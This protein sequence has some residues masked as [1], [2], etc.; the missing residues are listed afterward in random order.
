MK[1]QHHNHLI[2]ITIIMA[3]VSHRQLQLVGLMLQ[4]QPKEDDV[5]ALLVYQR[6]R[7]EATETV[8]GPATDLQKAHVR[9]L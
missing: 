6:R 9:R 8:R 7:K 3:L 5:L 1:S 4:Q 2:T